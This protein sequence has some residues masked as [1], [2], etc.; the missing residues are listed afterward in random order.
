LDEWQSGEH[1]K[2]EFSQ[3]AYRE[4]YVHFRAVWKLLEQ[5][6]PRRAERIAT[7]IADYCFTMSGFSRRAAKGIVEETE[8]VLE[9]LTEFGL[10]YS[11]GGDD[12]DDED[13]E[14]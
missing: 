9:G 12:E 7:D 1:K 11:L 5:R 13:D 8:D 4:Q 10:D 6:S 2:R 3:K 14:D